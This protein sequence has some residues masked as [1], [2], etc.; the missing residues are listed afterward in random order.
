MVQF[1]YVPMQ[2]TEEESDI[3]PMGFLVTGYRVDDDNS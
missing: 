2:V 1:E 3:N